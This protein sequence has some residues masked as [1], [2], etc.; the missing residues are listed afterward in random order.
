MK[1]FYKFY[2]KGQLKRSGKRLLALLMSLCLIGTMIPVTT[3]KAETG[4]HTHCICGATHTAIGDHKNEESLTWEPFTVTSCSEGGNF[5]LTA[6]VYLDGAGYYVIPSGKTVNICLNGHTIYGGTY[7]FYV[8]SGGELRITDCQGNGEL[9][10][11]NTASGVNHESAVYI[12]ANGTCRLYK[13]M[14]HGFSRLVQNYGNFYLYDGDLAG[15]IGDVNFGGGIDN[16]SG[17]TV[18]MYGGKIENCDVYNDCYG[19]GGVFN[20]GTFYMSGGTITGCKI[21]G[22]GSGPKNSS[23]SGFYNHYSGNFIMTGG[24]IINNTAAKYTSSSKHYG[25]G[26]CNYEGN[27]QIS[28]NVNISGN[29]IDSDKNANLFVQ[30]YPVNIR[31]K[32]SLESSIYMTHGKGEGI[33][34]KP[35]SDVTANPDCFH[36]DDTQKKVGKDNAGNIVL[37]D[38]NYVEVTGTVKVLDSTLGNATISYSGASHSASVNTNSSGVY[39]VNLLPDTYTVSITTKTKETLSLGTLTIN[40]GDNS[41]TEDYLLTKLTGTVKDNNGISVN[42]AK[43]CFGSDAVSGYSNANGEY[44]VLMLKDK[45]SEGAEISTSVQTLLYATVTENVTFDSNGMTKD[46]VL[47]NMTDGNTLQVSSEADLVRLANFENQLEGKTIVLT[48]DIALTGQFKG[49]KLTDDRTMT[50]KGNGHTISNMKTP[51]FYSDKV[52]TTL[53]GTVTDL[54]LEGDISD[55]NSRFIGALAGEI[56]DLSIDGC[57]FE[58]SISA[59]KQDSYIGGLVGEVGNGCKMKNCYVSLTKISGT[60]V[61]YSGGLCG[62]ADSKHYGIENCYVTISD[63]DVICTGTPKC[64]GALVGVYGGTV[65]NCYALVTGSKKPNYGLGYDSS[66]ISS[67]NTVS[68]SNVFIRSGDCTNVGKETSLSEDVMKA[69]A[70]S[71]TG[72]SRPLVDRLNANVT[73]SSGYKKW[74]NGPD[75]YPC[76][77]PPTYTITYLGGKKGTGSQDA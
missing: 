65:K 56:W 62:S 17:G 2:K 50:I 77:T 40:K 75:G 7:V 28:G 34:A 55:V 63:Y 57:S 24:S 71:A 60:S 22:S 44:T 26:V 42:N 8:A 10:R 3:A 38:A 4:S 29:K 54:H 73:D 14:L 64:E 43:I 9:F 49:I 25:Y 66:L 5:Y 16:N 69:A 68:V 67:S 37:M 15:N 41:K 58:G 18:Y 19:G 30:D 59:T 36:A 61:W 74:Y 46:F 23:G 13:G 70:G 33:I 20:A 76:F 6:D 12:K 45:Y 47:S 72:D 32:L 1:K 31:G 11:Y 51:L 52:N 21:T 53:Q 39:N 27:M 35:N 48:Q